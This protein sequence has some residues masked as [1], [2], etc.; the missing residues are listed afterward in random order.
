MSK[1]KKNQIITAFLQFVFLWMKTSKYI[2]VYIY[3][4]IYIYIQVNEYICIKQIKVRV[5]IL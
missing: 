1:K 4:Y 5:D 3:M 2:Y